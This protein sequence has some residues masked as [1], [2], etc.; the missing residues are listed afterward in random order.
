MTRHVLTRCTS[1]GNEVGVLV[2]GALEGISEGIAEGD[3][4]GLNVGACDGAVVGRIVGFGVGLTVN[5]YTVHMDGHYTHK[6]CK[7]LF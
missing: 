6:I 5:R 7:K 3:L 2:L 1:V 4:E